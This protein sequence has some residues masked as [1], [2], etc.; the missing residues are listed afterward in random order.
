MLLTVIGSYYVFAT[1]PSSTFTISPGIYP[2]APSYTIW[3]EG[4]YYFAKNSN[5]KIEFWGTDAS[6]VIQAAIDA[7]SYPDYG[8]ILLKSNIE[9]TNSIIL[10]KRCRLFGEG[11]FLPQLAIIADVDGIIITNNDAE[12]SNIYFI[13]KSSTYTHSAI[14]VNTTSSNVIH[15]TL[16]NLYF[17]RAAAEYGWGGTAIK[18]QAIGHGIGFC[19]IINVDILGA[20]NYGIY[21]YANGGDAGTYANGNYFNDISIGGT[22]YGIYIDKEGG[23]VTNNNLFVNIGV[24]QGTSGQETA[25]YI[26]GDHNTFL[27][28][29][30]WDTS[31]DQLAFNITSDA[32]W[33]EIIGATF[34]N[35]RWINN[36]ERTLLLTGYWIASA[37]NIGNL[38]ITALPN[39][40]TSTWGTNMTG[41]IWY[42]TTYGCIAYWNGTHVLYISGSTTPP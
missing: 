3:R 8:S 12:V 39:P 17:Y 29:K 38:L 19:H 24:N 37:G 16:Q 6:Q 26:E 28:V 32:R 10:N 2:G 22:K 7:L 27:D 5:G 31:S 30:V 13:S 11:K 4:D 9:I 14:L 15:V 20:W 36:G 41:A 18:L 25:L 35:N 21:I 40:D 33:T 34:N 42:D 23:A 1:A